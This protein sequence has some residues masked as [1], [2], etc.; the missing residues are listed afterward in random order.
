MARTKDA[1]V[2]TL[3]RLT[4]AVLFWMSICA[5]GLFL[6]TLAGI[7]ETSY[8][9]WQFLNAKPRFWTGA[10]ITFHAVLW[11]SVYAYATRKESK[12]TWKHDEAPVAPGTGSSSGLRTGSRR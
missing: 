9:P 7:Y 2:W 4:S 1:S 11:G 12:S 6:A 3:V 5:L 10:R 8:E